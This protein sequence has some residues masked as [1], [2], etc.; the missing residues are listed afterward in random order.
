MLLRS[1][2]GSAVVEFLLVSLPMLAITSSTIGLSWFAFEKVSLR[3][4][5]M[6]S[7]WRF[8]QPDFEQAD[9]HEYLAE[10]LLG[11]TGMNRF[12]LDATKK[13]GVASVSLLVDQ[14]ALPGGLALSAPELKLSS[15]APLET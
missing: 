2:R 10:K 1:S 9:L 7:A 8:S 12:S 4:L 6:E 15:H 5:S 13:D 14:F 3:V 11:Q